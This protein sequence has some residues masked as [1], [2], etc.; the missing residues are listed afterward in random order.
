VSTTVSTTTTVTVK[1]GTG[2]LITMA[3]VEEHNHEG[4]AWFVHEGK[5]GQWVV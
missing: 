3:E 5:V 1:Q 2:R 4:S